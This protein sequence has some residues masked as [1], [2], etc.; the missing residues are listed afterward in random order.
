MSYRPFHGVGYNRKN[1]DHTRFRRRFHDPTVGECG[2]KDRLRS[3]HT[4]NKVCITETLISSAVSDKR[5]SSRFQTSYNRKKTSGFKILKPSAVV[6][7]H[8]QKRQINFCNMKHQGLLPDTAYLGAVGSMRKHHVRHLCV[9]LR[10]VPREA[11]F[12]EC[13]NGGLQFASP[14]KNRQD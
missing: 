7:F 10:I 12:V 2:R 4:D 11:P 5:V 6:Q 8:V 1:G 3:D 13:E 9:P 14:R